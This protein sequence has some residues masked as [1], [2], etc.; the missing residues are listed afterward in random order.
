LSEFSPAI[1]EQLKTHLFGGIFA[2]DSAIINSAT[3]RSV[4]QG[5]FA[6]RLQRAFGPPIARLKW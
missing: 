2:R 5:A 1:D 6:H 3:E 4:I